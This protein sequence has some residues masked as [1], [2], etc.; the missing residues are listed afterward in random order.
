MRILIVE[1]DTFYA[2]AIA[3]LLID[4]DVSVTSVYTAQD[5][6]AVDI[7]S[8]DAAVVDVM[9]PNNPE[10]SGITSEESRGGF[11]TGVCVARRCLK[12]KPGMKMILLTSN[13]VDSD[14]EAWAQAKSIPYVCK[15]EGS[16]ALLRTLSRLG[17]IGSDKTPLAF[18]V[19]GHDEVALLQ[20]KNYIQNTLRWREP[21]ILRDQANSGRTLIEKFEDLSS[22]VDC[23]FV[24]LTPDDRVFTGATSD[25]MRRS[26]QN[27]IFELGFFYGALG[28]ASRRLFLLHRGPIE[29][30][31]DLSGVVWIDISAGIEAAGE[32]IRREVKALVP[33]V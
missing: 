30:P 29:L 26:R 16:T 3:E 32:E 27:V 5:A 9:L 10:F 18:I 13:V 8:Y 22:K 33:I 19:H 25:E 20:L 2:Q 28:R 1:D 17:L 7:E 12:Q 24:L 6:L 21:L 23:V 15:D 31:S 11:S 14:A 4:R